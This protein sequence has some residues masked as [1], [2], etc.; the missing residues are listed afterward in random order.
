M[1]FPTHALAPTLA[2][3]MVDAIRVKKD[4]DRLFPGKA[5]IAIGIAGALPDF[6]NPHLSLEARLSS[7]T[8]TLWFIFAIYPAY[9]LICR[10]WLSPL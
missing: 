7:W 3:M 5:L 2:A 9:L 8:H 6:L 10:K 4:R 1:Q